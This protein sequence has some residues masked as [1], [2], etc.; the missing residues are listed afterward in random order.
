MNG[1]CSTGARRNIS[2]NAKPVT[3][4]ASVSEPLV[5]FVFHSVRAGA[6]T[7]E[8]DLVSELDTERVAYVDGKRYGL[9]AVLLKVAQV[10]SRCSVAW[11]GVVLVYVT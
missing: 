5:H 6:R 9:F 2:L 4:Y 3:G 10:F 1:M 8:S 7:V 11:G